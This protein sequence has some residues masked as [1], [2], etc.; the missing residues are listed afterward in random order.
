MK[1]ILLIFALFLVGCD[2]TINK[3]CHSNG[4][5]T[6]S[7][8][9]PIELWDASCDSYNRKEV[10]GIFPTCF[11]QP[12]KCENPFI[13]QVKDTQ[14]NR[15][16]SLRVKSENGDV[17]DTYELPKTFAPAGKEVSLSFQNDSF[18]TSINGWVNLTVGSF[19]TGQPFIWDNVALA[20]HSDGSV[21][22]LAQTAAFG[23]ER[24]PYWPAGTYK[25]R[26]RARNMSTG[27]SSPFSQRLSL[28]ASDAV[29]AL[30]SSVSFTSDVTPEWGVSPLI[31]NINIEFTLVDPKKF[32]WFQFYKV[33]PS[34]G[35]EVDFTVYEIVMTDAP[36]FE[37]AEAVYTYNV[38]ANEYCDQNVMIEIFDT[39]TGELYWYSDCLDV[40]DEHACTQDIEYTNFRNFAGITFDNSSPQLNFVLT[41]PVKFF[42]DRFPKTDFAIQTVNSVQKLAS[43][44]KQQRKFTTDYM[45]DF[46]HRKLNLVFMTQ[47]IYID[48][49]Y[50]VQEEEYSILG[51]DE[52]SRW[53][54]RQGEVYLTSR[55][56]LQRSVL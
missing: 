43:V 53:P 2:D 36:D 14:I 32:I 39:D 51:G 24:A 13:G 54:V 22:N 9:N 34:S 50:W 56:F 3:D 7:P 23:Q 8:L 19:G 44:L 55:D 4:L 11:C 46:M 52:N 47:S 37:S 42:F 5:R 20:A 1:R 40:K 33:G 35:Y 21:S 17:L 25:V 29:N 49:E 45:P 16:Y 38:D 28:Y 27:G 6:A 31:E 30:G 48:G 15:N 26:V 10:C 12:W 18:N 41:V